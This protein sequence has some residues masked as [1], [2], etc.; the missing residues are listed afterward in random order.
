MLVQFIDGALHALPTAVANMLAVLAAALLSV[1][2]ISFFRGE[3]TVFR[4]LYLI[5]IFLT[6]TLSP[7]LGL[8]GGAA[9]VLRAHRNQEWAQRELG[10]LYTLIFFSLAYFMA[11]SPY[12]RG[13]L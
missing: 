9:I 2:A 1:V 12:V 13:L 4:T 3:T 6:G 7:I 5:I 10:T 8:I 11:L